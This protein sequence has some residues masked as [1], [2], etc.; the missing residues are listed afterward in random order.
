[1][2]SSSLLTLYLEHY[3]CY[4]ILLLSHAMDDHRKNYSRPNFL[5]PPFYDYDENTRCTSA[6][7]THYSHSALFSNSVFPACACKQPSTIFF[8]PYSQGKMYKG[9]DGCLGFCSLHFLFPNVL[10]YTFFIIIYNA[11]I[12]TLQSFSLDLFTIVISF[13]PASSL[14]N[15]QL[16]PCIVYTQEFK[17]GQLVLLKNSKKK[18]QERR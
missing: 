13:F 15:F 9:L 16:R 18:R 11:L 14:Y 5:H 4:K 17:P 3:C 2:R 10:S 1:M 7:L 8:V 12:G 6:Q